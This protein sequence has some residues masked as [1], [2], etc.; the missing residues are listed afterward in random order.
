MYMFE[1]P[2]QR[3][4]S[5]FNSH[6]ATEWDYANE[7]ANMADWL[8]A[9][10]ERSRALLEATSSLDT[11]RG[12]AV[13]KLWLHALVTFEV[14]LEGEGCSHDPY[15]DSVVVGNPSRGPG[16]RRGLDAELGERMG[17]LDGLATLSDNY[18]CALLLKEGHG[19]S[20]TQTAQLMGTSTAAARSI[21]YR[22]RLA[23]RS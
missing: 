15:L 10:P 16:N 20:V 2:L 18:R 8:C 11:F 4:L 1:S 14:H 23:I 5:R 6:Q 22:A 19:L 3:A 13:V 12:S 21:L 9:G 17:V 7:L